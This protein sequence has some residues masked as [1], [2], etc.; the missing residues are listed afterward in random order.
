MLNK[1]RIKEA[2]TNVKTYLSEGLLKKESSNPDAISV[3]IKNAKES[4]LSAEKLDSTK[5]SDLWVIVC[6]YYAMFYITNAVLRKLGYKA[7]EKI[8]HQ[9]TSDALIVYARKK[10]KE[11]MLEEYENA[12]D[13]AL[14]LAGLRADSLIESFEFEKGKRGRLQ[15]TTDDIE[16]QSKA[17]TSLKRAKEFVFEMEKFL[18]SLRM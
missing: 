2:E 15:Y 10:L 13:E 11:S 7:G 14:N 18:A 3:L 12:K 16:K 5:T 4:I 8:V 6:S 17:K 1:E 9:V